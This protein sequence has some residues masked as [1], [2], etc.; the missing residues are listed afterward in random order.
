MIT[1]EQLPLLPLPELDDTIKKYLVTVKPFLQQEDYSRTAEL[2][3]QFAQSEI[4][5]E[6]QRRLVKRAESAKAVKPW[7]LRFAGDGEEPSAPQDKPTKSSWLVDWW[8]SYSYLRYREPVVLNVSFF[9]VFK[10]MGHTDALLRAA[11][12]AHYAL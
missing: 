11:M 5:L 4:G 10:R 3:N 9:F 12:T 6:L 1:M 2:A 8:N 7:R